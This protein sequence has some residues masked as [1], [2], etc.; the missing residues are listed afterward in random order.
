MLRERLE[1][2]DLVRRRVPVSIIDV[3]DLPTREVQQSS[4]QFRPVSIQG[5]FAK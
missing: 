3:D 5:S 1:A 2:V 4:F